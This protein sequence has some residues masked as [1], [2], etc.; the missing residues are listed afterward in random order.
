MWCDTP[1]ETPTVGSS[2]DTAYRLQDVSKQLGDYIA[3]LSRVWV[4]G[5]LVSPKPYGRLVYVTLRDPD[6][7][8]SMTMVVPI[9]VW[10][11]IADS[12]SD[13]AR[14]VALVTPEWWAKKG[15]LRL[16]AHSIRA[17]GVGDLLARIE[18]LRKTLEVEGLFRADR[19]KPL[20]FLPRV[21]GLI[22]GRDT[23]ALKDVVINARRRWPAT[24]FEIREIALQQ[25]GTPVAA[26]K[27]LDEL[28]SIA[29]VDVIVIARGGGSF[30]DLL[31]W[32]DEGLVRAVAAAYKPVVS[33]IGHENDHPILDDVADVRASTPTDA[34][35]RIVPDLEDET[36][37]IDYLRGRLS[38]HRRRW[39]ENQNRHIQLATS[40]LR[41]RSPRA[42]VTLRQQELVTIRSSMRASTTLR[43]HREEAKVQQL[44]HRLAALSPF[45]VLSRGYAVATLA[46]GQVVRAE[47][48]VQDGTEVF[49]RVHEGQFRTVRTNQPK[50]KS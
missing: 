6:V 34:A 30:E 36:A 5:Q 8:M 10:G 50:E 49:V 4:E 18:Q 23:D 9:D 41:A 19:K 16:R 26:A 25:A 21:V 43:L 35:R 3:R 2:P 29:E 45:A 42:V 46:D 24:R 7:D 22:T 47:S 15:D 33:A 1:V 39:I 48:E 14:V 40:A 44:S 17:V 37:Q 27:A 13:G 11:S 32:S 28:Q 20:P 12:V 38:E 31:P